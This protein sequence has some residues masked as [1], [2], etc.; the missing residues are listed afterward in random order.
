MLAA[1]ANPDRSAIEKL[2][3]AE[4]EQ[5]SCAFQHDHIEACEPVLSAGSSSMCQRQVQRDEQAL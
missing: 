3:C 2:M 4:Q 5:F 1:A